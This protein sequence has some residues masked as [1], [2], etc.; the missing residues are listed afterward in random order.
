MSIEK[1][2]WRRFL[3]NTI[4][5]LA[6]LAMICDSFFGIIA[7]LSFDTHSLW[8]MLNA[9]VFVSA[10]PIYIVRLWSQRIGMILLWSL[11]LVRWLVI[12]FDGN[13]PG[14]C[15]PIAWP[16]GSFLFAGVVLMQLRYLLKSSENKDGAR[17]GSPPIN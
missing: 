14:L 1:A 10:L 6:V 17:A 5:S 12:C 4:E 2:L 13:P 7:S 16:M 3:L 11:F 8:A 15:N 9:A